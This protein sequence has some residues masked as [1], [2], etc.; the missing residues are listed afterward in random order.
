MGSNQVGLE[1]APGLNLATGM[2]VIIIGFL[3]KLVAGGRRHVTQS[4]HSTEEREQVRA[5]LGGHGIV[6]SR[7]GRVRARF[8][9]ARL[10]QMDKT[11]TN[12]RVTIGSGGVI[13]NYR[14]AYHEIFFDRRFE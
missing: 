9:W 6:F 13:R 4:E 2:R 5:I 11:L 14:H 1:N 10:V 12:Q 7:D 3:C 8:D